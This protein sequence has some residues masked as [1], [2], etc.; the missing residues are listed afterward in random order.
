MT[1]LTELF[2][3]TNQLSHVFWNYNTNPFNDSDLD[4]EGLA[5]ITFIRY[6]RL[7]SSHDKE[8][9]VFMPRIRIQEQIIINILGNTKLP[10]KDKIEPFNKAIGTIQNL[11]INSMS[12][13]E[14]LF[15]SKSYPQLKDFTPAIEPSF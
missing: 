4:F 6:Q 8:L 15:L 1:T 7:R 10:T 5:A 3:H 11:I 2:N 9:D 14:V 13:D 12:H